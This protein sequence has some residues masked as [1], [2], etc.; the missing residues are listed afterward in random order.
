MSMDASICKGGKTNLQ[1]VSHKEVS[2]LVDVCNPCPNLM[3][4][5][6]T[7]YLLVLDVNGLL[8]VAQHVQFGK[9]WKPLIL[10]VWCGNKLVS[11]QPNSL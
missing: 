5:N 3:V 1:I 8:C 6:K 2:L 10:A 9:R 4:V 11:F 7:H